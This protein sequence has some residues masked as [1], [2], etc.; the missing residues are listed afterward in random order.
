MREQIGRHPTGLDQQILARA[1]APAPRMPSII[2]PICS[3]P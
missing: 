1:R 2:S 3:R